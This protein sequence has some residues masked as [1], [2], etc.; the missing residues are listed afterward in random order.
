[1]DLKVIRK[2][3][4]KH[5]ITGVISQCLNTN[6]LTEGQRGGSLKWCKFLSKDL[7]Y[8]EA[9]GRLLNKELMQTYKQVQQ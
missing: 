1:M 4:R 2:N 5:Y 7:E 6:N 9:P 3:T 8:N